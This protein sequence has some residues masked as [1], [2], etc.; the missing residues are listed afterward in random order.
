MLSALA[1]ARGPPPL[2]REPLSPPET[3]I[4][5]ATVASQPA[6]AE[7][8]TIRIASFNIQIFG[9]MKAGKPEVLR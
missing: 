7:P 6:I 8:D 5:I 3:A 9:Q 2:H 1:P 4:L